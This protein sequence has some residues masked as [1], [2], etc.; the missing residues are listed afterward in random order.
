MIG[1]D[2]RQ[3]AAPGACVGGLQHLRPRGDHDPG[4]GRPSRRDLRSVAL[5]PG[6]L[7]RF[8]RKYHHCPP[9][10]S[11]PAGY[12][13]F[14]ERLLASRHFDVLLPTMSRASCSPAPRPRHDGAHRPGAAGFR[15]L[16]R[17][18]QQGR[19]QPAARP[20]RPAAAADP[21]RD[22]GRRAAR[23]RSGFPS[24]VKTSVGTA[25][26]G[27]WFVRDAGDLNRALYDL[28]IVRRFCRRG[29]GAG[30]RSPVRSRR[31]SRCSAAARWSAS[32]PTGRSQPASAAARRSRRA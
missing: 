15:R 25:S 24:V 14:V 11:D 7:F 23:R 1:H 26:R 30:S 32:M 27:I 20:A 4:A 8:V 19:L 28:Q 2:R 3:K 18:A 17:G 22:L 10:R 29:A 21:D 12:L 31:P 13:R 16:S 9:L 5:V 6:A